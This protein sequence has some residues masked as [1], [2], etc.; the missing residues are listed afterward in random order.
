MGVNSLPK[1]V[2]R[3]RHDC[4]L[5]PGLTAPESSTLTTRLPRFVT[6][7]LDEAVVEREAV[8]DRVLPA[9]SVVSVVG[10]RAGDEPIDVGQRRHPSRR[11]LDR[12]RDQRDV[13]V[14]RL[15]L[16]P[17][18]CRRRRRVAAA[19][20]LGVGSGGGCRLAPRG[21]VDVRPLTADRDDGTARNGVGRMT[22]TSVPRG[23]RRDQSRVG[24]TDGVHW[25]DLKPLLQRV[26]R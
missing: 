24:R 15:R 8:T 23:F 11:V 13:G 3:Q 18:P 14:G 7:Y 12:H 16:V 2:I 1:T 26:A 5:N 22:M 17:G 10:E 21:P 9:L 6:V 19:P 20:V 4:D 25:L